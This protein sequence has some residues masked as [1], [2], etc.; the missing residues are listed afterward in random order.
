MANDST[1]LFASYRTPLAIVSVSALLATLYYLHRSS[2]SPPRPLRRSN[3]IRR[4]GNTSIPSSIPAHG[5]DSINEGDLSRN[6]QP[7]H[8]ETET[9]AL[10]HADYDSDG[11]E[12]EVDASFAPTPAAEPELKRLVYHIASGQAEQEVIVH[13]GVICSVCRVSPVRGIRYKCLNCVDYDLCPTCETKDPHTSTHL[14]VQIKIPAPFIGPWKPVKVAYPA[15]E[16][17]SLELTE[18]SMSQLRAEFKLDIPQLKTLYRTFKAYAASVYIPEGDLV[19]WGIDR[20]TFGNICFNPLQGNPTLND[21]LLI[22]RIFHVWKN[23]HGL[24]GFNQFLA[25]LSIAGNP[26]SNSERTETVFKAFDLDGD[27][28]VAKADFIKMFEA[29][30]EIQTY[31]ASVDME[32]EAYK[33]IQ[34]IRQSELHQP[35]GTHQ[36]LRQELLHNEGPFELGGNFNSSVPMEAFD[37]LRPDTTN[38]GPVASNVLPR[39]IAIGRSRNDETSAGEGPSDSPGRRTSSVGSNHSIDDIETSVPPVSSNGLELPAIHAND[40]KEAL[41]A[42]VR[43]GFLDLIDPIFEE[44]ESRA[45]IIRSSQKRRLLWQ[46]EIQAHRDAM[47]TINSDLSQMAH[48]LEESR[49]NPYEASLEWLDQDPTF[50][51]YL[52]NDQSQLN[53]QLEALC[54]WDEEEKKLIEERK[55][56]TDSP[57]VYMSVEDFTKAVNRLTDDSGRPYLSFLTTWF[58]NTS[59]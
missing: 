8:N 50:P 55:L 9:E 38:L 56:R 33:R 52:A 57:D 3:A 34:S 15:R 59:F 46:T 29:H 22:N 36:W 41:S 37:L 58:H 51:Q 53:D 6:P 13:R 45:H 7:T 30:Y 48:A 19:T 31:L 14:L 5:G 47:R 40:S 28:F 25:K 32:L 26:Q 18:Q 21:N 17:P 10:G 11:N 43:G 24:I 49:R 54:S 35:L 39:S 27:E 1:K 44:A 4:P 16:P 12:T 23:S 2:Y 20:E 42:I